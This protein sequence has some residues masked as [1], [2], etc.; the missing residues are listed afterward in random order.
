MKFDDVIEKYNIPKV[1]GELWHNNEMKPDIHKWV[2]VCDKDGK[3][4]DLYQWNG[5]R[6]YTYVMDKDGDCDGRPSDIDVI[7]WKYD[8]RFKRVKKN[9]I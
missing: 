5:F 4:Y 7:G 9:C 6:W 1:V 8:E 2:I 3:E